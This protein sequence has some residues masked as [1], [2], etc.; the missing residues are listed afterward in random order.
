MNTQE[1]IQKATSSL[2][3]PNTYEF[4]RVV[5]PIIHKHSIVVEPSIFPPKDRRDNGITEVL[6]EKRKDESGKLVW[7]FIQML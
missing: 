3:S 2:P 6:F 1:I 7:K 5:I 4:D